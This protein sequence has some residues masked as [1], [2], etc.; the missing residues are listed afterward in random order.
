VV[1]FSSELTQI[2]I[3]VSVRLV[4]RRT[5]VADI[6]RAHD[7]D[8]KDPVPSNTASLPLLIPTISIMGIGMYNPFSPF[9]S[10]FGL[11]PLP[12][13]YFVWLFG[14]LVSYCILTQAIKVWY[15]RK[16][17]KWL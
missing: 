14:T 2:A 16:F 17:G 3:P 10:Y 8:G 9:A 13:V 1:L 6:D 11:Q 5:A 12:S 4:H 7:P 15:I